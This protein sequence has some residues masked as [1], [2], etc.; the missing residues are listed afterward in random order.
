MESLLIIDDDIDLC[1]MLQEYLALHGLRLTIY[2]DGESGLRAATEQSFDL[3]ILDLMVPKIDGFSILKKLRASSQVGVIMLTAHANEADRI[4]GF[5][6]GADDYL[7]KPFNPRELLGRIRAI[8]RRAA[9]SDGAGS[10]KLLA[11]ALRLNHQTHQ[12]SYDGRKLHLTEIEF[13]I[14]NVLLQSPGSVITREDLFNR[15]FKREFHPFDR[16]LDMHI[17]RLRKKLD[18]ID[19]LVGSIKTVRSSGYMF[20]LP[21][22]VS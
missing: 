5:E 2:H 10:S 11:G 14:F 7:A 12:A 4:H 20:N 16:S 22:S 1:S 3:V 6:V 13:M 17:S 21:E 19:V 15:V 8:L 18:T 9:K